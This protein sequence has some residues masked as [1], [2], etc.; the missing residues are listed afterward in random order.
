MLSSPSLFSFSFLLPLLLLL[1]PFAPFS[2]ARGMQRSSSSTF[3]S[4]HFE[5]KKKNLAMK[6]QQFAKHYQLGNIKDELK[7]SYLQA[8]VF[9]KE[10]KQKIVV[11]RLET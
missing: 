9:L 7:V 5:K 11:E 3:F 2:R 8:K 6:L 1:L 10:K 4:P